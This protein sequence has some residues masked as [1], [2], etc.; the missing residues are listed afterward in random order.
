MIGKKRVY[1]LAREFGLKSQEALL[2]LQAADISAASAVSFV[3]ENEGRTALSKTVPPTHRP[4][5]RIIRK[6]KKA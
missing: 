6:N 4:G 3:H 2:L 5:M 1:E